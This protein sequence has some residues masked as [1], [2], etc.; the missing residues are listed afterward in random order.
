MEKTNSLALNL[1]AQKY[2]SILLHFAALNGFE[3]KHLAQNSEDTRLLLVAHSSTDISCKEH[4]SE[5]CDFFN[6]I[7]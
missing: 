2:L 3:L 7:E 6:T 1:K 5:L 4:I